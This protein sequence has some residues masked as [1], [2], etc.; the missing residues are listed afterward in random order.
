MTWYL[1]GLVLLVAGCWLAA[2][3]RAQYPDSRGREFWLTFL[4]N[5]HNNRRDPDPR[6]RLGDSLYIFIV[7]E[8]PCRGF[9]EWWDTAGQRVQER[10]A[11]VDPRF[12]Y[13]FARSWWGL[14][15][16]GYNDSGVLLT[17]GENEGG[18]GERPVYKAFHVVVEEGS[19]VTVYAFQQALY[20]S[21]AFLVLPIDVLGREYLVMSY[22]SDGR[23]SV[24]G[25][26]PES[27]PSQF[28]VVAVE[29]QTEVTILPSAP[30]YRNGLQEQR[31][32]LNRGQVYLV[33]ARIT[34]SQL[35]PDLTGTEIR[36]TKPIAVFAG[37]QRALVPVGQPGLTSRDILVEQLP[38]ISTWGYSVLLTHFPPPSQGIAPQGTHRFRVLAAQAGTQ[39]FVNGQRVA[40]LDRGQVYEGELA[41]PLEVRAT[42][43]ILVAAFH[44][45]SNAGQVNNISDPFM[46]LIP[47]VQQFMSRYRFINAQK[48]SYDVAGNYMPVYQEQYATAVLPRGAELWLDGQRV[49]P[50]LLQPVGTSGYMYAWL[51]TTDGVHNIEARFADGTPAPLGLYVYG[52]GPADSYGY[53]GGASFRPLDVTP[54]SLVAQYRC[55]SLSGVVY[56][57]ADA[58]SRLQTVEVLSTDNVLV[59]VEPFP[60]PADSVRF[61]AVLRDV[62]SDGFFQLYA[63]DSA[64]Y[65]QRWDFAL[66][67]FTLRA[68][69]GTVQVDAFADGQR[70]CGELMVHNVGRLPKYL[71]ELRFVGALPPGT[72]VSLSPADSLLGPGEAM[73]VELCFRAER[74]GAYEARLLLADSCFVDDS[75]AIVRI[76][77]GTDETP[78]AVSRR[79]DSCGWEDRVIVADTG[80][81]ASGIVELNV[82]QQVNC[83]V[84]IVEREQYRVGLQVRVLD[85]YED[86]WYELLIRDAAGNE[87]RVADTLPGFT[88][89]VVKPIEQELA[90][91]PCSYGELRCDTVWLRNT[92]RFTVRLDYALLQRGTAFSIPPG[93]LPLVLAPGESWGLLVC[94]APLEPVV[95]PYVDTL[96][97]EALC[98][99]RQIALRSE[100]LPQSYIGRDQCGVVLQGR[101]DTTQLFVEP[102]S[103]QPATTEVRFRF[104]TRQPTEIQLVLYDAYGQELRELSSGMV[105]AGNHTVVFSVEP[106]PAGLYWLRLQSPTAIVLRPLLIVR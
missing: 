10:F 72:E 33:Q 21:D 24:G 35:R 102:P 88:V 106:Y 32:V 45:T 98:R 54:P 67:G 69:P 41:Q 3:L 77:I 31:V 2:E 30:T 73:R 66:S 53:V 93:Q 60:K 9:I 86:A 83:T 4:P 51:R 42:G 6:E 37:H 101:S 40:V 14:E 71:R 84:S 50:A 15:L 29:D 82:L 49:S 17:S 75:A 7:A 55:F 99:Y 97:F 92:G 47:P 8:G 5:Y 65:E 12:P 105:P 87:C 16:M 80:G 27:T 100:L 46:M 28:A 96:R 56:D 52:Y 57:T 18:Q 104:S 94:F 70:H 62:F 23:S 34:P 20:S 19:E 85:P 58:D 79:R 68:E 89:Q 59:T 91:S 81:L 64:G 95:G 76:L 61:Q 90:V 36:A 39:V 74:A 78:P 1:K 44:K 11:I 13:V 25:I 48:Y 22:P 38:P 103:P 43:P 63:R 26:S